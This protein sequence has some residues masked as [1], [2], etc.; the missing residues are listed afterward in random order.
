[1]KATYCV[2]LVLVGVLTAFSAVS[3]QAATP[4]QQPATQSVKPSEKPAARAKKT[5]TPK[6]APIASKS[7]S[8][9]QIAK[10]RIPSANLDL[11]LPPDMV[12]Q[13]QPLGTIPM[14]KHKPLLPNMFGEKPEQDSPFQ[15]NGRLLSNEMELQLRNEARDRQIEGAA[16]DFQFKQ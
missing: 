13:L 12:K 2:R 9:R 11:S 15:L 10:Q 5:P 3:A 1:M 4:A 14:P 8:A 7:K 6:R 16:L